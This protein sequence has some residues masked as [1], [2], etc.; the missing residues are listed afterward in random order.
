MGLK[1]IAEG[2]E[3]KEQAEMLVCLERTAYRDIITENLCLR[4]SFWQS[5]QKSKRKLRSEETTKMREIAAANRLP[6][7][8]KGNVY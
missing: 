2:V 6:R 7:S 8:N 4:M 3:E 1:V 5:Y